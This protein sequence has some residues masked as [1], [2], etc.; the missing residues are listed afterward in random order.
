MEPANW[1][2]AGLCTQQK[3]DVIMSEVT[4]TVKDVGEGDSRGVIFDYDV[5]DEEVGSLAVI[6]AG[7]LAGFA[8]ELIETEVH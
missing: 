7:A 6:V 8:I 2:A 3:G 4:I 1:Q 5:V